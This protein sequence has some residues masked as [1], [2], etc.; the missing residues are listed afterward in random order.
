MSA[1][2][3]MISDRFFLGLVVLPTVLAIF[4]FGIVASDVYISESRFVVRSPDK[5]SLTGIGVLLKN[6]GF[7]NANDEASAA[8]DYIQSRDALHAINANN[9]FAKAYGDP[10]ISVLNRA[11]PVGMS[12]SFEDLYKYFKGKVKVDNNSATGV[13]TLTVRAFNPERARHFNQQ[14]LEMAEAT[15]NR[16]NARA[17]DDLIHYAE[18][19]VRETE[20]RVDRTA[21][22]L[23]RYRNRHRIVDPEKQ[24]GM[25]LEMVSKLQDELI[26]SRTQLAQLRQTA[27]E[28]PAIPV[29]EAKIASLTQQSAEQMG[30]VAGNTGSLAN[31][32]Q[33]YQRLLLDNEMAV[34]QLG[35]AMTSLEQAQTEARRK[36]AYVERIAQ[37]S[38]PDAAGEP[39]RFAGILGTLVMGLIFWGIA[40][41]L[42]ASIREHVD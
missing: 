34:R 1:F 5:P 2:Q 20:A 39:H 25:Q 31:E 21:S 22:A 41:M 3:K 37:P 7:S 16:L 27:P 32:A 30:R 35:A 12:P 4:Y 11:D 14:L 10:S 15:V 36:Q 8:I 26:A 40:R 38:L 33:Q 9:A 6:A 42:V 13:T 18:A 19:E 28:N 24:A 23:A 17:R 29:L